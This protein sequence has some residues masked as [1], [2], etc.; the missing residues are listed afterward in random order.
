MMALGLLVAFASAPL[1]A[2][3]DNDRDGVMLRKAPEGGANA[4]RPQRD[5]RPESHRPPPTSNRTQPDRLQRTPPPATPTPDRRVLGKEPVRT[6]PPTTPPPRVR[7]PGRVPDTRT[8]PQPVPGKS[9]EHREPRKTPTGSAP[10]PRPKPPAGY[11]IDKRHSHN[12]YYPPRGFIVPTLPVEHRVV[13]HHGTHYYYHQ[14]IWYRPS[15]TR[16]VVV[17]PPFGLIV[18][19]LPPFFTVVWY[20]AVPYYYADGVYYVWY[21]EHHYYVVAEP[22]PESELHEQPPGSDELFVYPKQGQSEE[23]QAQ[24]RYACHRW[25]VDQT[26]FDPTLPGGNVRSSQYDHKRADYRRAMKACLEARGYSVQ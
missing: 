10:P 24:D 23:R 6:A 21:P 25:A 8:R 11:V 7:E 12:H 20:G 13:I 17:L 1:F 26:G 22:P 9:P 2:D 18:P 3:R 14:G 5:V 16:F 19:V 4:P 15:G